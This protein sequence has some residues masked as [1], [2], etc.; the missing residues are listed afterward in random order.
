MDAGILKSCCEGCGV[1]E[2]TQDNY[3]ELTSDRVLPIE[4]PPRRRERNSCFIPNVA[5][6]F[7]DVDFDVFL[8]ESFGDQIRPFL[9]TPNEFRIHRRLVLK[10]SYDGSKIV[11]HGGVDAS[12]FRCGS[13]ILILQKDRRLSFGFHK[14]ERRI[15][16]ID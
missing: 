11:Q 10:V 16:G 1:D 9:D 7:L 4:A 8:A 2:S 15:R 14:D 6:Q 5:Q 12:G 13:R 3:P